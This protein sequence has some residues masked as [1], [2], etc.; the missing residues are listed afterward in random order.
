MKQYAVY[1]NVG[2]QQLQ[3][4]P[5]NQYG[6][7]YASNGV[8]FGLSPPM[9]SCSQQ[10][11][12][13]LFA[14]ANNDTY[15]HDTTESLARQQIMAEINETKFLMQGSVTPEAVSFWKKHLEDLNQRLVALSREEQMRTTTKMNYSPDNVDEG[16]AALYKSKHPLTRRVSGE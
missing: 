14:D 10:Q 1:K 5:S 2:P 11:L 9:S 16:E 12:P 13:G 8:N 7:T 4:P 3:D 15:Y 6:T